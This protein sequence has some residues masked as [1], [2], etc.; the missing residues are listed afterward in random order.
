MTEVVAKILT[1]KRLLQAFRL[2]GIQ[3]GL[4]A[5]TTKSLCAQSIQ[6]QLRTLRPSRKVC[7]ASIWFSVDMSAWAEG[8]SCHGWLHAWQPDEEWGPPQQLE[9]ICHALSFPRGVGDG[10]NFRPCPLA[11]QRAV[12]LAN[13]EL[14][15][16]LERLSER[17]IKEIL[18]HN[19]AEPAEV[20]DVLAQ[21]A[22]GKVKIAHTLQL[23]LQ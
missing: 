5:R 21:F 22:H 18:Q 13:G 14:F 7:A 4:Q 2:C 6:M 3:T 17:Y 8:C 23:K 20:E 12:E 11:G 19:A 9:A 10:S 16:I 15:D 1:L